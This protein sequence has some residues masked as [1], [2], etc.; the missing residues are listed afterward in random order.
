MIDCLIYVDKQANL[1]RTVINYLVADQRTDYFFLS[2][3][4]DMVPAN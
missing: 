4:I 2:R 3:G 1:Y